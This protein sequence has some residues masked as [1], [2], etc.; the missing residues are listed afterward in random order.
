VHFVCI[1]PPQ[2]AIHQPNPLHR[3]IYHQAIAKGKT[4]EEVV[5]PNTFSYGPDEVTMATSTI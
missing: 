5:P 1:T 2:A 3:S 4:F